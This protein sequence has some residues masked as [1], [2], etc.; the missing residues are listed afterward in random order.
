[1]A[2]DEDVLACPYSYLEPMALQ[3][4]GQGA[5]PGFVLSHHVRMVSGALLIC[6]P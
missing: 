1:M 4:R 6:N 2:A 5:L 3:I